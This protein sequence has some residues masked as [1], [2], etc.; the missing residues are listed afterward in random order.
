MGDVL[1]DAAYAHQDVEFQVLCGHTHS[2][3]EVH[4]A[5]NLTVLTGAAK[6]GLPNIYKVLHLQE[7]A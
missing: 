7:E 1:L 2:P 5:S 3:G 4:I 6:Y